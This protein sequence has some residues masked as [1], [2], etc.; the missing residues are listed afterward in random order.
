MRD[1]HRP[2]RSVVHGSRG[3]AATSHPLSTY[4]A[5]EVLR[6][7]GNAID[8][9]V[10]AC[11]LQSVLEPHNTGIGGDCFALVWRADQQKLHALN[12]AGHAPEGLSDA[13][14][15]GQGLTPPPDHCHAKTPTA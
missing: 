11:A 12:G 15:L 10:T 14:L 9:A 2:G 6:T 8:A 7:G 13:W 4:A 3:A 5:I 1:L